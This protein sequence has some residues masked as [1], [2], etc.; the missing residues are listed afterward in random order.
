MGADCFAQSYRNEWINFDQQYYKFYVVQEGLYR[1]PMTRLQELELG[2]DLQ[3]FQLWRDGQQV[4]LY[5][6][7]NFIEFYAYPNDGTDETEL[8]KNPENQL[9]IETS[10]FTDKAS[11]FLSYGEPGTNARVIPIENSFDDLATPENFFWHE[12][13]KHHQNTFFPGTPF[14]KLTGYE[15]PEWQDLPEECCLSDSLESVIANPY[16]Y[17][18]WEDY[19]YPRVYNLSESYFDD[20]EGWASGVMKPMSNAERVTKLATRA[21]FAS[22]PEAQIELRFV[23]RNNTWGLSPDHLLQLS[24]NGLLLEE[25]SFEGYSGH[26]INLGIA[27]DRIG[28]L[29]AGETAFS[30][31]VPQLAPDIEDNDVSLISLSL[32]YPRGFDLE[33]SEQL[34]KL[35]LSDSPDD[36]YLEFNNAPSEVEEA[37]LYQLSDR[38]RIAGII[39]AD[40]W[41]FHLPSSSEQEL[42]LCTD[43][44]IRE[45]TD[46]QQISFRDFSKVSGNFLIIHPPGFEE[47]VE[48]Y[49]TYRS[50]LD[51]GAHQVVSASVDQLVDQF[52]Y[53]VKGHPFCI[54]NLINFAEDHWEQD[55][56]YTLLA[57]KAV[58]H[59]IFRY[60]S[61]A[62][63]E[64]QIP[65]YGHPESDLMFTTRSHDSKIPQTAIGRLSVFDNQ[66]L[67]DYLHKVQ[68]YEQNA[69]CQSTDWRKQVVFGSSFFYKLVADSLAAMQ[70][71]L[72]SNLQQQGADLVGQHYSESLSCEPGQLPNDVLNGP[73]EEGIGLLH[74]L[75]SPDS[76]TDVAWP[77]YEPS[78]YN[79]VDGQ[80][81]FLLISASYVGNI[82]ESFDQSDPDYPIP[83]QHVLAPDA[84]AIGAIADVRLASFKPTY[85]ADKEFFRLQY[86][87]APHLPAGE[88]FRQ[89]VENVLTREGFESGYKLFQRTFMGDPAVVI[90]SIQESRDFQIVDNTVTT[91]PSEID[92]ASNSF[93]LSFEV[94]ETSGLSGPVRVIVQRQSDQQIL[95][96]DTV[97]L[98]GSYMSIPVNIGVQTAMAIDQ[99]IKVTLAPVR[100]YDCFIGDNVAQISI[101]QPDNCASVAAD[102]QAYEW[103]TELVADSACDCCQFGQVTSYFDGNYEY[104]YV[105]PAEGCNAD[106]RLYFDGQLYCSSNSGYSCYLNYGLF[107]MEAEILWTCG[108]NVPNPCNCDSSLEPVCGN[109]QL[110]YTNSCWAQ[111]AGVAFEPGYCLDPDNSLPAPYPWLIDEVNQSDC[112]ETAAIYTYKLDA[113]KFVVVESANVQGCDTP[114]RMFNEVGDLYC[115]SGPD[116]D[117]IALYGLTNPELIWTC[118]GTVVPPEPIEAYSWLNDL[119]EGADCCDAGTIYEYDDGLFQWIFV[120][121]DSSCEQLTTMYNSQGQLYCTSYPGYDC[122]ALYGLEDAEQT[123]LWQCSGKTAPQ[124]PK[125]TALDLLIYPNPNQGAFRVRV[126]GSYEQSLIEV[127]DLQGQMLFRELV[128]VDSEISLGAEASGLYLVRVWNGEESVVRRVLVRNP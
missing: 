2:D 47:A 67:L 40:L 62:T 104:I 6:D 85:E 22:G 72:M 25:I 23:G 71:Q 28:E 44:S 52:A 32:N 35:R 68:E 59:R 39:E 69:I 126:D 50:S 37:L 14:R 75:S 96:L 31:K 120:E 7:P 93:D 70:M 9:R 112:C 127:F 53:G 91:I 36:R 18:E 121:P 113:Y 38:L 119:T 117:C 26:T 99:D 74:L 56:A 80:F 8:Y 11:Y 21:V 110:T 66:Q 111:C 106:A 78:E 97:P 4:P 118:D 103:L 114:T 15:F 16:A 128:A 27:A 109:D 65:T 63:M 60:S 46:F 116:Y 19:L 33:G 1:I 20:F 122:V 84:G 34:I 88:I 5:I 12:V 61:S 100:G 43:S 102:L 105:E 79:Y 29:E 92:P 107:D 82:S 76:Y 58:N 42:L 77:L 115:T 98:P 81:P 41:K 10:I 45:I 124:V 51:G 90:S 94:I 87:D 73:I 95:A 48:A 83:M 13:V 30:C 86:L 64:L 55:L 108:N 101:G 17:C 3:G 24:H 89:S 125:D 49:K 57:G 54:R 123:I